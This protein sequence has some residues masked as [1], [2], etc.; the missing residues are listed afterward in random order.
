MNEKRGP[1][2]LLT[3]A[4]IGIA[5]G[6]LIG[7]VFAPIQY[8]DTT[9]ATLRGDFKDEYRYMIAAAYSA[10]GNLVRARA[11]LAL[12]TDTDSVK[13]LG[14]QAQRML[15]NNTAPEVVRSLADLSEALQGGSNSAPLAASPQPATP[16]GETATLPPTHQTDLPATSPPAQADTPAAG[17][18]PTLEDLSATLP[19]P[20]STGAPRPTR[21]PTTTPGAPFE[22]IKESEFCEATQAGLLQVSLQDSGGQPAAGI[23]LVITWL[24]GEEHFFTGLKPEL[25]NGYADFKMTPDIEYALNLSSGGQRVTALSSTACTASDGTS[26]YSGIRLEFKQP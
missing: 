10:T 22:L 15:A 1:W 9:P 17:I 8:V 6:L 13:A 14:D 26:V 11:R 12:L 24:G 3:G 25:G 20:A 16:L 2:Y 19:A 21:I 4:V 23:E 7:W 5:I 18:T